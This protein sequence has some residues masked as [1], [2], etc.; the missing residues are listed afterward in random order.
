VYVQVED[1][2]SHLK[3]LFYQTGYQTERDEAPFIPVAKTETGCCILLL[4][5]VIGI[6]VALSLFPSN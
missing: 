6:T 1:N 5:K 3:G 4:L 2:Y